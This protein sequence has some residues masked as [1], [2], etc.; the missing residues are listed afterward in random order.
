MVI[1]RPVA[2]PMQLHAKVRAKSAARETGR[3]EVRKDGS[4]R[5]RDGA[6]AG[7]RLARASLPKGSIQDEALS[8]APSPSGYP[9][10]GKETGEPGA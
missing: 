6:P 1:G 10:G 5:R 4:S 2:A 3:R 9:E 8:G 7:A